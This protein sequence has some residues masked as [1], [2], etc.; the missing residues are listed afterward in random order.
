MNIKLLTTQNFT[1]SRGLNDL[2]VDGEG[3]IRPFKLASHTL[4]AKWFPTDVIAATSSDLKN[5]DR[6]Q[7][8]TAKYTIH[9][10]HYNVT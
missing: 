6:P 4:F 1:T 9:T 8:V 2:W 3:L 10:V 5:I 7:Y